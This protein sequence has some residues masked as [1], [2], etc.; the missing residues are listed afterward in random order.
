MA[1]QLPLPVQLPDGETF[2]SFVVGENQQLV[3]QLRTLCEDKTAELTPFLTFI[4][5]DNGVGKSHLLYAL[6]HEAQLKDKTH[7]Y[8]SLKQ[9]NEFSEHLLLGLE[10]LDIVCLDDIHL[11][12]EDENWQIA[13]FD[14]INRI[15]ERGCCHLVL[16]ANA[17][18]NRLEFQ[19]PDLQSRLGWG[20]SYRIQTLEES[21]RAEALTIRAEQRGLALTEDVARFLIA[22]TKRDMPSL[23]AVLNT[24]D[25]LSLQEKRRLT[26]PFIKS[27]LSI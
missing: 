9:K 16:T 17:G 6:C 27:A 10:D 24:L 8:I 21:L 4:S 12:Q 23:M 2:S 7:L 14:L 20:V 11:I 13:I 19:L 5:G 18:P 1:E 25:Q 15:K 26:I 22:H 3:H